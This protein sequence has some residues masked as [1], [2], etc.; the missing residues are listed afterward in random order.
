MN[1]Y[2]V[3]IAC[4]T[5]RPCGSGPSVYVRISEHYDWIAANV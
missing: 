2:V 3:G 5:M 4:W 1:G